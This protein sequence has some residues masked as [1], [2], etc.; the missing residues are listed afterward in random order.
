MSDDWQAGDLALC[1]DASP[2]SDCGG[3]HPLRS[4]AVYTV[5]E[6]WIGGEFA[7]NGRFNDWP[8]GEPGLRFDF[9]CN[10]LGGWR[11]ERFRKIRPHTADAEDVETIRLLTSVPVLEPV[12]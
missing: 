10:K 1:V 4:G 7:P 11:P 9:D 8:V 3:P 5:D 12:Q 2:A 6:I